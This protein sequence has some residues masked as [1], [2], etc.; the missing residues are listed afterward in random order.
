MKM[1][2]RRVKPTKYDSFALV[3][4]PK[5]GRVF[6]LLHHGVP[7]A[8]ITRQTRPEP[9]MPGRMWGVDV[10]DGRASFSASTKA[11]A[12]M[13]AAYHAGFHTGEAAGMRASTNQPTSHQGGGR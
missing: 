11:N 2:A 5:D 4:D 7:V 12:A 1:Q 3:K 13:E 6:T 8:V 10:L 9:G